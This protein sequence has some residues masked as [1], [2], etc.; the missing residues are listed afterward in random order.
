MYCQCYA[1]SGRYLWQES[2]CRNNH[3]PY[4]Y[5]HAIRTG[6]QVCLLPFAIEPRSPSYHCDT[7]PLKWR[8]V[9]PQLN[10]GFTGHRKD[11]DVKAI[12]YP[13]AHAFFPNLLLQQGFNFHSFRFLQAGHIS[14]RAWSTVPGTGSSL[15]TFLRVFMY[16]VKSI[17]SPL[18]TVPPTMPYHVQSSTRYRTSCSCIP[19]EFLFPHRWD[20]LVGRAWESHTR[21]LAAASISS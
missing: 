15:L 12:W 4:P 11:Q 8:R 13:H 5:A 20:R 7:N 16:S 17:I 6:K 10:N 21:N 19:T 1:D 14:S 9:Y 2:V 18:S 3:E